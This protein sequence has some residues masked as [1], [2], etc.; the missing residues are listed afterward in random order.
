M[1]FIGLYYIT[2]NPWNWNC[3]NN[4]N[5]NN[6]NNNSVVEMVVVVVLLLLLMLMIVKLISALA[7]CLLC[8]GQEI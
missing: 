1:H 5:N 8:A 3:H 6:N 2:L 4:N 7:D